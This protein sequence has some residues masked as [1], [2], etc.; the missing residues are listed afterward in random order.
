M[1]YTS[2]VKIAGLPLLSIVLENPVNRAFSGI[3]PA[4]GIIAI[5]QRAFGIITICQFGAGVV[6]ISQFGVG[7]IGVF[8]FGVACVSVSQ[9]AVNLV[10][11]YGQD[12]INL[13]K[14]LGL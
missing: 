9:F 12:V 14:Y 3:K 7:L 1:N 8:Q 13:G 2:T 6:C 5:G 4:L 11:G 10:T